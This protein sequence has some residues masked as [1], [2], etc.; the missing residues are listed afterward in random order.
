VKNQPRGTLFVGFTPAVSRS[1]LKAMRPELRCL[2]R[3][4][5]LSLSDIARWFN[6]KLRGWMAYYG[7]YN[8]SAM[9]ALWRHFNAT[10]VAW[11]MQKFRSLRRRKTR[12]SRFLRQISERDPSLFYHWSIGMVGVFV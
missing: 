12:A 6:P 11:A 5:D 1:A 8:P 10:L 2:R 4:S 7:R 3:R 9:Y